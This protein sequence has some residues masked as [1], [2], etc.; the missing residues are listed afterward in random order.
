MP[1]VKV[2][3]QSNTDLKSSLIKPFPFSFRGKAAYI[4]PERKNRVI[5][6]FICM[7]FG[8][9]CENCGLSG[10]DHTVENCTGHTKCANCGEE[11]RA[12]S[13]LCPIYQSK[14]KEIVRT[15]LL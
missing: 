7:R 3:H 8:H 6:C 9:I 13:R 5:L 10:Q 12:S 2:L 11:Y 1:V 4:E 14:A 15:L